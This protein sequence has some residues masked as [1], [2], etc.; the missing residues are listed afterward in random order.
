MTRV[1]LTGAGGFIGHHVLEHLLIH[2]DWEIICTDSF[3]HEGKTERISDVLDG[4]LEALHRV[5][6]L[7]HDL[8][9]PW[10]RQA[11]R[12]MGTIDY[13]LN[14]ASL[15]NVD[16]SISEP[17]PFVRDNVNIALNMLEL[18]RWLSPRMF[19]Q[20]ST[21]EVYGP[22]PDGT[23]HPEWS[24]TLPS[25][26]YSASKAA[27][28]AVAIS[29]WRTYGLPLVLV[30]TM[31][32]VGER[33]SPSKYLPKLITA[34]H[35]G[36]EVTVHGT[37]GRIGARH[38]LHARNLADALLYLL[39]RGGASVY[40]G[41]TDLDGFGEVEVPDRYNIVG[42]CEINNLELAELV[43]SHLGTVLRYR[44]VDFHATRPG[45]DRR[46]ALDGAKLA[47]SGWTAPI[48]L[49][50]SI[51]RTIEWTMDHPEWLLG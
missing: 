46:Y 47:K 19:I 43:A 49:L 17:V 31:N 1:L 16:I 39:R 33:Q 37:A 8:T 35:R 28:E 51:K 41:R 29:Y 24:A 38:Y 26:P 36:D 42:E 5:Q 10:S 20:M 40:T 15:S 32:V 14:L 30:N 50:S 27:Q 48:P 34:I 6:V 12:R 3:R 2:T 45:H 4:N 23:A 22:A 18:S 13:V 11:L 44:F 21:D 9:V 7:V 25:N